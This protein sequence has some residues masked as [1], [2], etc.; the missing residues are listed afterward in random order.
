MTGRTFNPILSILL[1]LVT[2]ACCLDTHLKIYTEIPGI[3]CTRLADKD[4]FI[5]C[6]SS[7]FGD[8]GPLW[9]LETQDDV[10]SFLKSPPPGPDKAVV[11]K[12]DVFT[13]SNVKDLIASGHIMGIVV[14]PGSG[15]SDGFSPDST[16]PS[17]QFGLQHSND[18]NYVWNPFGNSL[19]LEEF[20]I[21][22]FYFDNETE[23]DHNTWGKA[24]ENKESPNSWPQHGIR[25]NSWM[26]ASGPSETCLRRGQ[27]QAV[28]GK[29]V[30]GTFE[31]QVNKSKELIM[32]IAAMDSTAF[33]R[34]VSI[35]AD[36]GASGSIALLLVM[37][38]LSRYTNI[39]NQ[40]LSELDRQIL[41]GFFEG[42]S[43]GYMG[44]KRFVH[45]IV[46]FKCE[47]KDG[48]GCKDPYA[49]SLEF[50]NI[51]IS[52][53]K[54]LLE[55]SQVANAVDQLY[56][57]T[58][59]SQSDDNPL[60][61]QLLASSTISNIS[62]SMASNS[63]PG[64][65]PGST[66]TFLKQANITHAV[67]AEHDATYTNKYYHSRLDNQLN[68]QSAALVKVATL[69]L[70]TVFSLASNGQPVPENLTINAD[71]ASTLVY[72][73]SQNM[74]C[75]FVQEYEENVYYSSLPSRYT[76]VWLKYG[77]LSISSKFI[78]DYS[79]D[80]LKNNV[81][82][83][84]KSDSDCKNDYVCYKD[85]CTLS[86]TY[87][88]DALSLAFKVSGDTAVKDSKY[89]DTEPTWTESNWDSTYCEI[90]MMGN[91]S[92]EWVV[93]SLGLVWFLSCFGI[94]YAMKRFL[95][96]RFKLP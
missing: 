33:F 91:P 18:A 78:Y 16:F 50:Q 25:F 74:S 81:S 95:G 9:P 51:N 36:A 46:N 82:K 65:P 63:T 92:D 13:K 44:S 84:C 2:C 60:V 35:G 87:Y 93:F 88:H 40:T 53:I 72:C 45:D 6:S 96:K 43:W 34:D 27:C 73:M 30:W 19:M 75:D 48:S 28:G 70:E 54:Y 41:F 14:V 89:W 55:V 76:S 42:E 24:N 20:N 49:P 71:L 61:Q 68:I 3:P 90:F 62:V 67:L 12:D 15:P 11:M 26:H 21:P 59:H 4:K 38:A 31:P 69:V 32:V 5:G 7:R 22:M 85:R 79:F 80:L 47:K 77:L 8:S 56:I 58:E 94:V 17:Y 1:L 52:N 29:S 86:S 83:K 10:D 57:H 66:M 39:T 23:N 64:V 37:D